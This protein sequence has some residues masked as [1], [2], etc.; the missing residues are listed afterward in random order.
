MAH[1]LD[2]QALIVD[3]AHG[4]F[5][6]ADIELDLDKLKS[7]QVIVRYQHTGVW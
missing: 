5:K 4:S 3:E 7:D 2:A 6:L 1:L